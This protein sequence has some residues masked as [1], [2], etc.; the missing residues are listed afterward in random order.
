MSHIDQYRKM[1]ED[2]A[3]FAGFSLW[4][5][6]RRIKNLIDLIGANTVMDYGCGKG[7]Q[8]KRPVEIDGQKFGTVEA[9]WDVSVTKWDPGVPEFS[10][11]GRGFPHCG[12]QDIVISTDVLE[13][14]PEDDVGGTV[15]RLFDGARKAVF[16]TISCRL[17]EKTLPN[18]ENAHCTVKEPSWWGDLFEKHANGTPWLIICYREDGQEEFIASDERFLA[19]PG[20][21]QEKT[22]L[23][24]KTQNCVPNENI[25]DQILYSSSLGFPYLKEVK[26]HS[27]TAVVVSGGPSWEQE[28]D[29]IEAD[30]LSGHK[31][32]CV[33][34]S[35]DALISRGIIPFG[36]FL[37]DP[38]DHVKDFI[39]NPHPEVRYITAS[40]VHRSTVDRLVE[41]NARVFLYHALVGAGEDKICK[42][43]LFISGGSTSATRGLVVLRAMGFRHIRM[44]GYDSCYIDPDQVKAG[45]EGLKVEVLGRSFLTDAELVAQAQDMEKLYRSMAEVDFEAIGPGIIPHILSHMKSKIS[46]SFEDVYS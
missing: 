26:P 16:A 32:F 42:E 17:A 3:M 29:K 15:V 40:M 6:I 33:K 44:Y 4:P 43:G 19:D 45:K 23:V 36:C 9:Y 14:I 11:A 2:P 7:E 30:Y 27:R 1:H 8:Y 10:G 21:H 25:I 28:I 18:G 5:H 37:L 34:H 41:K 31:I 22:K 12:V 13:H 24:V 46:L 39:E 38:R 35:H 20:R